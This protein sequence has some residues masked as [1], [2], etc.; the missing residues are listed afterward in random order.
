MPLAMIE[1]YMERLPARIA[2]M[3]LAL[4]GPASLPHMDEAG[5]RKTLDQWQTQAEGGER[6]AQPVYGAQLALIG[7][8]VQHV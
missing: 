4:A 2:E 1:A 6:K 3:Q 7:I 5:R 8:G